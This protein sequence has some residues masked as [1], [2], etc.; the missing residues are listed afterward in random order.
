MKRVAKKLTSAFLAVV[1]LLVT[2]LGVIPPQVAQ[3]AGTTLIIHYGGR[4]DG[5]YDGWNLWVWEDGKYL[6]EMDSIV[7]KYLKEKGEI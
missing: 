6:K 3:A 7:E 5:N 4:E 1:F 2:V